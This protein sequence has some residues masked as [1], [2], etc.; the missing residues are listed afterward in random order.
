MCFYNFVGTPGVLMQVNASF[1]FTTAGNGAWHWKAAQPDGVETVSPSAFS[2]IEDCMADAA[3][4]GY[5]HFYPTEA[6]YP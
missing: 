4:H 5:A 3:Q 1:K 2:S 6:A